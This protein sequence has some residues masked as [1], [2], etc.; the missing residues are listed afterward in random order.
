MKAIRYLTV[1]FASLAACC[2]LN[3]QDSAE[4]RMRIERLESRVGTLEA[5]NIRLKSELAAL[6]QS[7]PGG[8]RIA[9]G[10]PAASMQSEATRCSNHLKNIGLA[11]RIFAVDHD[12]QFP[13][14]VPAAKGGSKEAVSLD[15][16]GFDRNA[17]RHFTTVSNELVAPQL[18]VCPGDMSR[19][20]AASFSALQNTNVSYLIRTGPEVKETNPDAVLA[21]CP[22]H[23]HVLLCDGRVLSQDQEA[24]TPGAAAIGGNRP[25]TA[26][27][28]RSAC[29]NN[30]RQIDGAKEQWALENKKPDGAA[31]VEQG[32]NGLLAYIKGFARPVC[33]SGGIY[34]LGP[35]GTN[36]TCSI[37]GH[38]L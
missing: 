22:I 6:R 34:T 4:L 24:G 16:N 31:V 25:A 26:G 17:A 3:A 37:P 2:A 11:F 38:K 21:V 27:N 12:D 18:V 1:G 33:P 30:L 29:I 28:S 20:P 23:N 36:P 15:E 13:F 32:R 35:V 14:H 10:F 7:L 8:E 19:R 9:P 5:E